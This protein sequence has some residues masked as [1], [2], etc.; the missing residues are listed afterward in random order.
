LSVILSKTHLL[1]LGDNV[2]EEGSVNDGIVPLLLHRDTVDLSSLD[3]G[4]SVV[5]VHLL[6]ASCPSE[7]RKRASS[8]KAIGVE[9][10]VSERVLEQSE[11]SG[12]ESER[13]E[14]WNWQWKWEKW[15]WKWNSL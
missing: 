3:I 14:G 5:G 10:R 15:K 12:S 11:R 13:E 2:L 8:S 1:V 6:S 7:A 4:R 9:V